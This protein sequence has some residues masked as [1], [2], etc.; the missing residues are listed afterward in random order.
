MQHVELM[1]IS[2]CL[3]CGRKADIKVFAIGKQAAE[4]FD[5]VDGWINDNI[6]V[7]CLTWLTVDRTCPRAGKQIRSA[8]RLETPNYKFEEL[9][10]AVEISHST[11]PDLI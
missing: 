10:M 1:A 4:R 2:D 5:F 11:T 9:G 7:Q 6:N 8:Q 3:L